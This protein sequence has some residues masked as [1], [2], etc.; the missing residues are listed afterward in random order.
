GIPGVRQGRGGCQQMQSWRFR[1]LIL[2]LFTVILLLL[3]LAPAGSP[4]RAQSFD[5]A[6]A[7]TAV[8]TAICAD[9]SL[10]AQDVQLAQAYARLLATT[11]AREPEKVAQIRD[12]KRRWI[13]ERERSCAAQGETP[14]RIAACIAGFYHAR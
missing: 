2:A 9:A 4:V 3:A 1:P 11:Q 12:E 8:E 14:A 7:R 6:K 13:Q 10:K 5:C